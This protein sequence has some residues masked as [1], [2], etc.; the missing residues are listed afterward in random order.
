M[1]LRMEV[2]LECAQHILCALI[3]LARD[4]QSVSVTRQ[5]LRY[6][7]NIRQI[8]CKQVAIMGDH[9]IL[10]PGADAGLRQLLPRKGRPRIN[11]AARGNIGMAYNILWRDIK[12]F[13]KIVQ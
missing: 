1:A 4:R 3:E 8:T 6:C 11:F 10:W 13:Y 9:V 5:L 7:R 12:A 2:Q